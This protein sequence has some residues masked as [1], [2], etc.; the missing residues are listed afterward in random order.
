MRHL[1]VSFLL[2][3]LLTVLVVLAGSGARTPATAADCGD[4]VG[5]CSCGDHVITNTAL[6]DTDPVTS[7]LCPCNG[8][9]VRSSVTLDLGG[10]TIRG[11]GV[12]VG[13]HI[14]PQGG[15]GAVVGGGRI[16]SF[17]T[18]VL[19]IL[20]GGHTRL[21]DIQVV[22]NSGSGVNLVGFDSVVEDCLVSRNG[23]N[24]I[25][26]ETGNDPPGGGLVQRCRV[27][28]NQGDGIDVDFRGIVVKSN[29]VRRNTGR[30]INVGGFANTVILNRVESNGRGLSVLSQSDHPDFQTVVARNVVLRNDVA[31]VVITGENVLVDRNWSKYNVSAG[32]EIEGRGH[33]VTLNQAVSNEFDGFGVFCIGCRFERNASNYNGRDTGGSGIFDGTSGGGTGGTANTYSRNSCTGNG[34]GDSDPTGLCR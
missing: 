33:T 3:L 30:G 7:S 28:D 23:G 27:E 11:S 21:R 14:N 6:D 10:H 32:F 22:E 16:A 20:D 31:G 2:V 9:S 15:N 17:G 19:A 29:I 4:G 34:F 1:H 18:G 26:F 5:P 25:Q 13:V 24:G 8:L 12:C